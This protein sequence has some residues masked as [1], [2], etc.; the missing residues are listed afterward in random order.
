MRV[1]VE[2]LLLLL[3]LIDHKTILQPVGVCPPL[4]WQQRAVTASVGVHALR[5]RPWPLES[6]VIM[7]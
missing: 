6:V 1:N 5:P 4:R 7:Q 3:E 2:S